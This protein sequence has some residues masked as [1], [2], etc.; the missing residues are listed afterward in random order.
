MNRRLLS[1]KKSW[2]CIEDMHCQFITSHSECWPGL[3]VLSLN[4]YSPTMFLSCSHKV[5]NYALNEFPK[6]LCVPNRHHTLLHN[7][8][9]K[10]KLSL[11]ILV[12]KRR[13]TSIVSKTFLWWPNESSHQVSCE[14]DNSF[15]PITIGTPNKTPKLVECSSSLLPLL[16]TVFY[17]ILN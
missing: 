15:I 16:T 8:C 7:L 1:A 12:G 5:P 3:R 9:P 13:R 14:L 11:P 10:F 4:A 6:F 17:F 2:I